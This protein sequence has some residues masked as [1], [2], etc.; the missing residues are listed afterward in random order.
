MD[1][2][3]LDRYDRLPDRL[4]RVSAR[5]I[6]S[7]FP[8]PSLVHL[9]GRRKD[10][11]V[12]S[13]LIHGNE[14]V[15]WVALQKLYRWM[16]DH[17]LPRSLIV[18]IANVRAAEADVR[19]MPGE[20][21]FNR[22][23]TLKGDGK[24]FDLARQVCQ[25][26]RDA[27]PFAVID[28]HNNTGANPHYACIHDLNPDSRQLASLFSPRAII[29]HNPPSMFSN[30][31]AD[32]A[33]S[34]TAECGQDGEAIG[35]EAAFRVVLDTL[36][37]DHWRGAEDQDLSV[38]EVT[39]RLEVDPDA[40][41]VFTHDTDGDLELPPNLEHWNFFDRPKGSTFARHLS[42]R[43]ALRVFDDHHGEITD[44]FLDE[45]DGRLILKK[46]VTPVML[47]TN[48]RAFR[49]DCLGYFMREIA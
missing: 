3:T 38:Y 41:V 42:G 18:F 12:M 37:L 29:T 47:T 24:E 35:E 26:L 43:P 11:V 4:D 5:E 33:P 48:E 27:R 10:P 9:E 21:D 28:L 23:W 2:L 25:A 46:T 39:G 44:Q 17:P 19:I 40:R 45:Q 36:H 6:R 49:D 34:I 15:G 8:N 22:L 32:I 1:S 31:F 7:L 13:I 30:A 14:T 20:R 16:A